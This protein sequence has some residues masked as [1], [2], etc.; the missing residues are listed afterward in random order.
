MT[1]QQEQLDH[2]LALAM[3]LKKMIGTAV[4]QRFRAGGRKKESPVL[5]AFST[6]A[7]N[8]RGGAGNQDAVQGHPQDAGRRAFLLDDQLTRAAHLLPDSAARDALREFAL[9]AMVVLHAE[10]AAIAAQEKPRFA[11]GRSALERTAVLIGWRESQQLLQSY[12]AGSFGPPGSFSAQLQIPK[13]TA[14]D[15]VPRRSA[16]GKQGRSFNL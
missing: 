9:A 11:A 15:A 3:D 13:I 10:V 16:P 6:S 7:E 8:R 1:Q 2:A 14:K 5:D 12:D 4:R